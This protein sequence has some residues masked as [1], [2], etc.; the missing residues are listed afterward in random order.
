MK[1]SKK[2]IISGIACLCLSLAMLL[3]HMRSSSKS[4]Q[5]L[6]DRVV[7][8]IGNGAL[9]SGEQVRSPSG[10]D[11]ILSAGHCHALAD[12]NDNIEVITEDG[13]HLSRR[14][15]QEDPMSDLL[16]LEGIPN[17]QGIDIAEHSRRFEHVRTFTHGEGHKTY[18]T[19]GDL[20]DEQH[21]DVLLG[22]AS[23]KCDMPKEKIKT[24]Q[25]FIFEIKACVLSVNETITTAMIVPGSSGGMV[26]DDS[27]KLVGVC[28]ASD[29]PFGALVRL[30][31]I[32]AFLR[33]Y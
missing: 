3:G 26:V 9:C 20:I 2:N 27:G 23:D 28:S 30:K 31:D 7:M 12:G 13:R 4:N 18:K 5:W 11:Y 32:K 22:E 21:L 8:L 14:V 6:R 1:K 29:S 24:M 15:I 25:I 19:E 16:L 10:K 33:N 17:L